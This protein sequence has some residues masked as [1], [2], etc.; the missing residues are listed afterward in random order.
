MRRFNIV[1]G[2]VSAFAAVMTVA[3]LGVA[4]F[5]RAG[6]PEDPPL[7]GPACEWK[8]N[9]CVENGTACSQQGGGAHWCRS[10]F[11]GNCYCY[12]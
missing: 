10:D 9:Q 12:P 5:A 8:N 4:T 6:D 2:F 7:P 3:L 1:C 11:P